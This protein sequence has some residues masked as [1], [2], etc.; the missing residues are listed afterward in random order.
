MRAVG[1]AKSRERDRAQHRVHGRRLQEV[2][3]ARATIGEVVH[4]H[5]LGRA[6]ERFDRLIVEGDQRHR[7][8]QERALADGAAVRAGVRAQQQ[9]RRVDRAARQHDAL[10]RVND[11]APA[12]PIGG[13]IQHLG[14]H[15]RR[16]PAVALDQ[17]HAAVGVDVRARRDRVGQEGRARR[18]LRV[19]RAAHAAVAEA[20]A[21]LDAAGNQH[22]IPAQLA[23]ALQQLAVVRVHVVRV[24]RADIQAGLDG[25]EVRRQRRLVDVADAVAFGPQA[26]R[27]GRRA[28]RRR[29]VDRRAAAHVAALQ[30][31]DGEIVG[32]AVAVLLVERRVRPRLLHVEVVA[33]VVAA[34]LEDGDLGA[35]RGQH[36]GRDA[37]AG[38]AA[39]DREVDLVGGHR[40][41]L[42]A[43]NDAPGRPGG[44]AHE[45]TFG[46]SGG[47]GYPTR[48]NTSGD[49]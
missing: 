32:G 23:G 47:P 34:L 1:V 38:A 7:R 46:T 15:G 4:G 9:R 10:A 29:P 24:A 8:V 37:A 49:E 5:R 19:Q 22:G 13:A 31:R 14:D 35:R 27:R 17:L 39:D 33:R 43:R 3:D 45:G 11:Q 26:Q 28:E 44:A 12:R 36:R 2:A 40:A 41:E 48:A 21:A 30:D 25:G 20:R 6:V 42:G 16:A 18:S